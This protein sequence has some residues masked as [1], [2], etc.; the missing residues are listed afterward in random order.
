M[1]EP[2][3]EVKEG[4]EVKEQKEAA[5]VVPKR[6]EQPPPPPPPKIKLTE[7]LLSQCVSNIGK[8]FNGLSYAYT[9]LTADVSKNNQM[10]G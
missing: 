9:K 2:E 7:G 4:E 8:T 3:P 6:P 1:A 10:I 5:P